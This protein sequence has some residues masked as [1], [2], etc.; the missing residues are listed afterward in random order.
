[1]T[2]TEIPNIEL[3]EHLSSLPPDGREVFLLHD[4]QIR[5]TAIGAS[6]LINRMRANHGLGLLETYVLGQAYLAAGLL[7]STVKE[8]DRVQLNIE[9]GGPI[10]GVYT[11]AWANGA[12]RGYLKHNPIPLEK[13][14]ESLDLD[15]LYGPGFLTVTKILEGRKQPFSGQVM[16]Q[17]GDLA[18]DLAHYFRQSEQTPT[19]II[20]S[21]HFDQR[22]NVDG[23]GAIFIQALP[24]CDEGTLGRVEDLSAALPSLGGAI[25][26]GESVKHFVEAHYAPFGVQYLQHQALNFH[27]PCS[28]AQYETYLTQLDE[29]EQQDILTHGP[30]PLELV[31][32]N[33]NTHYHFTQDELKALFERGE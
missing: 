10:G 7:A 33:C 19:L 26:E 24:G 9:C 11:E 16:M 27:C 31:C 3:I 32:L 22:G 25:A 23:S 13:P 18:R 21:V 20:L 17:Y 2:I 12:V 14:L 6:T 30:F 29:A 28:R 8:N 4:G 15:E 1:M 5:L